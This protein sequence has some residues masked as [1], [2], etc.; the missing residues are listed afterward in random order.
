VFDSNA[1]R[2][3]NWRIKDKALYGNGADVVRLPFFPGVGSADGAGFPEDLTATLRT[4][5]PVI[6]RFPEL[7]KIEQAAH[8][9]ALGGNR[10]DFEALPRLRGK[11][12]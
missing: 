3:M 12:P 6:A 1:A 2:S 10:L 4:R 7:K 11:P 8:D 9:P 5:R